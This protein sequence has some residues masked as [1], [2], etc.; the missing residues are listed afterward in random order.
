LRGILKCYF[1]FLLRHVRLYPDLVYSNYSV[2]TS[3]RRLHK[4]LR[5]WLFLHLL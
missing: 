4:R 2:S 1:F 3:L 5:H